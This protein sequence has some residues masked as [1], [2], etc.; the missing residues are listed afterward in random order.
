MNQPLIIDL[1]NVY[2][3]KNYLNKSN[4]ACAVLILACF[5][6]FLIA[7]MLLADFAFIY[8]FVIMILIAITSFY[9]I[10]S[11][12]LL[13]Y[14]SDV[15]LIK[16]DEDQI[17]KLCFFIFV[18][19]LAVSFSTVYYDVSSIGIFVEVLLRLEL[20]TL[21]TLLVHAK[22]T[23]KQKTRQV[24]EECRFT[25]VRFELMQTPNDE[26]LSLLSWMT[27]EMKSKTL[28]LFQHHSTLQFIRVVL[29][30]E[31]WL[32][33]AVTGLLLFLGIYNLSVFLDFLSFM[34][35][36]YCIGM[37]PIFFSTYHI[38]EVNELIET[39]ESD[40]KLITTLYVRLVY[41][42]PKKELFLGTLITLV[43]NGLRMFINF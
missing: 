4:V 5:P 38:T 14:L 35:F 19:L 10:T 43:V 6:T 23:V 2:H 16:G 27:S 31:L 24:Y 18:V 25:R 13:V 42:I 29:T 39:I 8:I 11:N 26:E 33:L 12:V 34:I 3:W 41:W 36:L 1:K 22:L 20:S 37:V 15:A 9:L 30:V 40:L 17:K 21:M 28:K 32:N 7:D